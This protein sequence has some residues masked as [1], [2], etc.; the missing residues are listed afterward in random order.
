MRTLGALALALALPLSLAGAASAQV[1]GVVT[2]AAS[3][4]P[5]AGARVQVQASDIEAVSDAEG[6]FEL[7]APDGELVVAAALA[8]HYVAAA[9]VVAPDDTVALALEAVPVDDPD[10]PL[11]P[12]GP[13]MACHVAQ[14]TQWEASAMAH[15]GLNT[16][17]FDIYD[18]TGTE[19]G[20]GGF[21]YTRDSV[22]AEENPASECA[23][24]HQPVPW[25]REPFS[26]LINDEEPPFDVEVG[27]S[28]EVCHRIASVDAAR[29]NFPGLHPDVVTLSRSTEPVMYGVMGDASYTEEGRMRAA[30]NP[31]LPSEVCALCHQDKNDPDGD[32]DFE[33]D[34]GV[35]SEPTYVEW[36]E[37][38]YGDPSSERFASCADCH[39]PPVEADAACGVLDGPLGRPMGDVRSHRFEGTTAAYLD[40]AVTMTLDAAIEGGAL[41]VRVAVD[42]DQTGHH[43]PTGV[44]IRNVILVV[45]AAQAGTELEHTG[46]QV[47]HELG[48]VGDPAQG[49]YAGLPGKLYAKV[50]QD[51]EGNGPTFFTDARSIRFDSR[52]PALETDETEYTFALPE[53]SG[54][55][56]VMARLI[57]RRSWRALVDAKGWTEDGHGEPLEDVAA[58]HFGHLMEQA[59]QTVAYTAPARDAGPDLDAGPGGGDAGAGGPGGGG[60]GCAAPGRG[61]P[62]AALLVLLSVLAVTRR[63]RA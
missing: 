59:E 61:G 46:E 16:W 12:P 6:R 29:P 45:S 36:I 51:G 42:N 20:M 24:C 56:V 50:N 11:S 8:G 33:E 15:A 37:S 58:P 54:D 10:A 27:V 41:A 1:S 7:A 26:A 5:V 35:I 25:L 55:I 23:S 30:Y 21:V 47:V 9:P 2:S 18:G 4:E 34:D 19:G 53:G 60:C 14:V 17:V 13:C 43:V 48:G 39:M 28:C 32:G 22:H 63:R 57:Y 38:E 3:G 44:T 49:Y 62:G 52:I 40:N 31:Q